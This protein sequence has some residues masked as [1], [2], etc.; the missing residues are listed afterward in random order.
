[1]GVKLQEKVA[2]S[3]GDVLAEQAA[4]LKRLFPDVVSEGKIDWDKLRATLV[5]AVATGPERFSF[6]WSGKSEAIQLLQTPS[7]ATLI[8]CPDES[9]D[10][11]TTGNLFIEGDNLEVLKLLF[12]PYFG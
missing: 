10:F 9:V 8:P 12:K 3:S 11:D 4:Q 5:D 2:A 1:M 7:Q 6:T